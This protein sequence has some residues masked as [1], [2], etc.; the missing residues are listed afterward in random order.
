MVTTRGQRSRSVSLAGSEDVTDEAHAKIG[1]RVEQLDR[2]WERERKEQSSPKRMNRGKEKMQSKV[3]KE[4]VPAERVVAEKEKR[5]EE[6]TQRKRLKKDLQALPKQED[7]SPANLPF[8]Q[9]PLVLTPEVLRMIMESKPAAAKEKEEK[10]PFE[11]LIADHNHNTFYPK[12]LT[13][14]GWANN[15]LILDACAMLTWLHRRSEDETLDPLMFVYAETDSYGPTLHEVCGVWA[16]LSMP[17]GDITELAHILRSWVQIL[18]VC[19][20]THADFNGSLLEKPLGKER[21]A[22]TIFSMVRPSLLRAQKILHVPARKIVEETRGSAAAIA[23]DNY[24]ALEGS[25]MPFAA[26]GFVTQM[27]TKQ[28]TMSD[29]RNPT[30][31][32]VKCNYCGITLGTTSFQEHNKTCPKKNKD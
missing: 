11:V 31:K 18:G 21:Y 24:T 20:V 1:L 15:Q 13:T 25:S 10:D 16:A 5:R 3:R 2:R 26:G 7:T 9:Q 32:N 27:G 30:T 8:E 23:Y 17:A 12:N 6:S 29:S 14:F 28:L 22:R 4:K 19:E